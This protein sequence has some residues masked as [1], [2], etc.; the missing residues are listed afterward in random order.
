[1][2]RPG[3]PALLLLVAATRHYAWALWPAADA[4]VAS[5][6]LG[7]LAALVLLAIVRDLIADP[8]PL[9]AR[10]L[11]WYGVHEG[12][13]AGFAAA[14]LIAPWPVAEGQAIGSA[15]LGFDLGLIGAFLLA[16]ISVEIT[17]KTATAGAEGGPRK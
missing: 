9:L 12:M 2:T 15:L 5:K 17:D 13:S 4:G 16:V 6:M 1:V 3:L 8:S 7:S 10:V 11:L 14:Y